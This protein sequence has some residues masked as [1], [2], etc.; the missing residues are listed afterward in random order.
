MIDEQRDEGDR[1]QQEKL[2][3]RPEPDG[4]D[5]VIDRPLERKGERRDEPPPM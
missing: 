5:K 3:P 1:Q 2:P 4:E